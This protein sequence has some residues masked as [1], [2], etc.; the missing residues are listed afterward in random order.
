[1][2]TKSAGW[3]AGFFGGSRLPLAGR[4]CSRHG[5]SRAATVSR[6]RHSC[7]WQL[8]HAPASA[9]RAFT[10]ER[11]QL[12]ARRPAGWLRNQREPK[13]EAGLAPGRC[14]ASCRAR[15]FRVGLQPA[16]RG[17][18][19]R[20]KRHEPRA[21]GASSKFEIRTFGAGCPLAKSGEKAASSCA[22]TLRDLPRTPKR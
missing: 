5:S 13:P 4:R 18:E 14:V 9:T 3:P 11:L 21:A 12:L 16:A 2:A 19:P 17:Q 10:F 22:T 1:M 6:A 8:L 7:I 15:S 20:A